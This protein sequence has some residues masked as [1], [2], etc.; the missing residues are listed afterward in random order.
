MTHDGSGT[1]GETV[2]EI[3][4]LDQTED[5]FELGMSRLV[6][7]AFKFVDSIGV[8]NPREGSS[9]LGRSVFKADGG[10]IYTTTGDIA[11][12]VNQ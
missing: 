5:P 6:S 12:K 10:L 7:G 8:F 3:L 4:W 2:D 9:L 11:I 1:R